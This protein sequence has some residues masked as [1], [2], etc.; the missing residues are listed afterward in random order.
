MKGLHLAILGS[1]AFREDE[2]RHAGFERADRTIQPGN[3][4]AAAFLV[5]RYLAGAMQMPPMNGHFH[6]LCL[7]RIRNW[8]GRLL[9]TRGVSMNEVWL[10]V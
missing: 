6:K 10:E 3:R 7:A 4:A 1:T 5:H 2:E 9:K 8:K